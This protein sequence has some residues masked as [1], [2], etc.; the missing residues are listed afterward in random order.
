[1]PK[2]LSPT[3]SAKGRKP[4]LGYRLLSYGMLLLLIFGPWLAWETDRNQVRRWLYPAKG[5]IAAWSTQC[6][7]SAPSW[8]RTT[9]QTLAKQYD[10]P[11]NQLV[12]VNASGQMAACVNGWQ[13]TPFFSPR[14]NHDTPLRLASLS[15]IVSFMGLVHKNTEIHP[16]TYPDWLNEKLV[17]IFDMQGGTVADERVRDIRIRHL[18]N[19]TAGFDRLR[20]VDPMTELD[21]Q[22]WCPTQWPMLAHVQLDFTPGTRYAYANLSYC[23]AAVAYEKRFGRSLWDVLAQDMQFNRYGLNYL[24]NTDT[25]V[26]YNFM[27]QP[28]FDEGYTNHFDWHALRAPMGM[29]GNA[30]G[31]ARFIYDNRNL[32]TVARAMHNTDSVPCEEMRNEACF[33]GFLERRVVNGTRLWRQ[34]GYLYGMAATFMTD[35]AGNFVVWLGA[36]ESRPILAAHDHIEQELLQALNTNE[37]MK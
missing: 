5:Q 14:V 19:H 20:S 12:F 7:V 11:A 29:T 28:F 15:K 35:Q 16:E 1:M 17:D 8:L 25:P 26:H 21:K 37:A 18:I 13:D 30:Q 31:L 32:I 34:R 22:P 4:R 24:E 36:G 27:H 2:Q 23:L 9:I 33:D 6:D 10:S 3:L